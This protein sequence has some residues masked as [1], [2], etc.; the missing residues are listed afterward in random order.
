MR[1]L[2][3][4]GTNPSDT[5]MGTTDL[6]VPGNMGCSSL[7]TVLLEL[8]ATRSMIIS[9]RTFGNFL[10]AQLDACTSTILADLNTE[11]AALEAM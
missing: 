8:D 1:I 2:L 3:T 7:D 9:E 4:I 11:T 10:D 5:P 6:V